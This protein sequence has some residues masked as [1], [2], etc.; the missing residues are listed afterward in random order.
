MD[1]IAHFNVPLDFN[2]KGRRD[3]RRLELKLVLPMH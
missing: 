2:I 3:F 1:S